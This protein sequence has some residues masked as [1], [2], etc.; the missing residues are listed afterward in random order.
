MMLSLCAVLAT[1]LGG[2]AQSDWPTYHG[3]YDLR[4]VADAAP[5]DTLERLWR[6]KA[7]GPIEATPVSGGGKI[8]FT[9]ARNQLVALDLSGREAWKVRIREEAFSAPPLFAEGLVVVGSNAGTLYAF[10]AATG[11]E[12][13]TYKVGENI[14]GSANRV[15]L[16]DGKKGVI[17]ISQTDGVLHCVDLQTGKFVW[18]T[19]PVERCDGSA[20]VANGRIV[21]GSCASALHVFSVEKGEKVADISLEGDHQVA[22]GVAVSGGLAFAGSRNGKVCAVDVAAGKIDWAN[23]DSKRNVFTTPAVNDRYV[24]F[25]S[26]DGKVYALRR[27]TGA[28]V[29]DF[30]TGGNPS[31]PVI[32]GDR[33]VVSSDGSL[34]LLDLEKGRKI[35]EIRVSD[36][37]TSPAVIGGKV[38]IGA[39][40]GTVTAYGGG[41]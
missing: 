17:A 41:R 9:A 28:K 13:W 4:G 23:R 2:P 11:K 27:G 21:L 26:E 10:D 3:G 37:I 5:P 18:K 7:D 12:K 40:D 24:V 8:Y 16:T 38:I 20:G 30:D 31:S 25:G 15:D 6:F 32:A 19:D 29:W 14:Q 35:R 1:A 34:Y 33:V 22:A 39:D 36:E